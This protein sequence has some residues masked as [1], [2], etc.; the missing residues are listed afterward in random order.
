MLGGNLLG[1]VVVGWAAG[2]TS[3][4]EP[5]ARGAI[6]EIG[7]EAIETAAVGA[8]YLTTTGGTT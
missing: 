7:R 8:F 4:F 2:H 3:V 1:A 6:F 5:A